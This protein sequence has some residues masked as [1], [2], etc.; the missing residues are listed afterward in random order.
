MA[1]VGAETRRNLNLCVCDLLYMVQ[2]T[3]LA[4]KVV[5]RNMMHGTSAMTFFCCAQNVSPHVATQRRVNPVHVLPSHFFNTYFNMFPFFEVSPT[6]TLYA[7]LF[8]SL[9]VLRT[10]TSHPLAFNHKNF[11]SLWKSKHGITFIVNHLT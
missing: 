7:F 2:C 5:L 10:R 3:K 6:K 8:S 11:R 4:N 1:S 9:Y